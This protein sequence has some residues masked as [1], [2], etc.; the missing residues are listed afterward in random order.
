MLFFI[1]PGGN[2]NDGRTKDLYKAVKRRCC[3]DLGGIAT[4]KFTSFACLLVR[5]FLKWI[6]NLNFV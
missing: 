4:F 1:L 2:P 6:S 3:I 5:H